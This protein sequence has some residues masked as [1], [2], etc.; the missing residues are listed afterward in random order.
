MAR[1]KKTVIAGV[2]R[3]QAESAFA[4]YAKSDAK[5]QKIQA[6]MDLEQTR[7][8]E[9]YADELA[10]LTKA[11]EQQFEVMQAYATEN[12]ET[13]FS[14]RKSVESAHGVFGFRTGT[15][16]LKTVKGITWA[17]A[18]QVVKLLIPQYIR[19]TEEIAKDK[20]LADRDN[21]GMQEQMKAAGIYVDQDETFFVEPKKED[22]Q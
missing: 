7:I 12:R 4:E 17:G 16:K 5:I 3:E 21:E 13:L 20:I 15:P 2:S 22:E 8:R 19:T 6:T 9:K 10:S 1:T 11:R 14:K 18:L